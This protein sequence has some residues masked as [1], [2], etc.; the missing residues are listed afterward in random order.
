MHEVPITRLADPT[1][2]LDDDALAELYAPPRNPWLRANFVTSVDGAVEV[3]G[4][5]TGLSDPQDQHVLGLLRMHSD[6][7]LLGAGTL[8]VERYGPVLLDER[9]RAWRRDRGMPE[10]PTLVVVSGS[11]RLDPQQPAF[12][13]APVRPIVLTQAT[14]PAD[15]RA[16][17]AATTDVLTA[18]EGTVD[19]ATAVALLHRRGL[20]QILSEGGPHLLAELTAADLVDELCLTVSPVL[21][22]AGAGRITAGVSSPL[23]PMS[24]QPPLAAG[25]TLLL[26]YRRAA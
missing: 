15:R 11:L 14:A 6:A 22:G 16:A 26:R 17:L 13:G 19:L 23:R 8:R 20:R 18:G 10:H 7:L 1:R 2:P 5:S 21:A 12:A 4:R 25:D 9:R 24:L 3:D